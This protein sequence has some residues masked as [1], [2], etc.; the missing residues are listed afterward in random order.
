VRQLKTSIRKKFNPVEKNGEISHNHII[1]FTY[2]FEQTFYLDKHLVQSRNK[3]SIYSWDPIDYLGWPNHQKLTSYKYLMLQL[4]DVYANL[5]SENG[6]QVLHRLTET[7]HYSFCKGD[8]SLYET[9]IDN[10][11]GFGITEYRSN[12]KYSRQINDWHKKNVTD[13]Q[14][15]VEI[16]DGKFR[17]S[18]G[19]HRAAFLKATG[20][21]LC[22]FRVLEN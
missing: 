9:Y 20:E 2:S 5:I 21:V 17:I 22:Q 4:D 10:N 13:F 7:P 11:L 6:A 1:H 16:H 8:Y 15:D 3:E 14:I 18:D 19:L 12:D